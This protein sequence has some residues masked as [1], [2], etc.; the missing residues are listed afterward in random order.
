MTSELLIGGSDDDT[1]FGGEGDDII[2]GLGGNDSLAGGDGDDVVDGGRGGDTLVGNAGSDVL[3]GNAGDDILRGGTGLDVL[4]GGTGNDVLNGGAGVDFLFGG[5][6]RDRLVAT[7]IATGEV[8][9]GGAGIDTLDLSG[10][11]QAALVVLNRVTETEEGL[12]TFVDGFVRDT[13]SLAGGEAAFDA[14]LRGLE[15]VVGTDFDDDIT[16]NDRSN[17]L[18]GGNGNDLLVGLGGN[19]RLGGGAGNDTL[20]GGEGTDLARFNGSVQRIVADLEDGVAEVGE[21]TNTLIDIENLNGSDFDDRI[22]GDDGDNRLNGGDGDDFIRGRQGNDIL[23]GGAGND[24][25]RGDRGE[26]RLVVN[27]IDTAE[28]FDGGEDTNAETGMADL[29]TGDTVDLSGFSE[30]VFVDLDQDFAGIA[31]P[32]LGQDGFI[33]NIESVGGGEITFEADLIDVEN[34]FGTA[35]DD[36]LFGNAEDNVLAGLDGDDVFHAFAGNDIYDGGDGTDLALFNQATTG[37]VADLVSGVVQVGT[38]HNMLVSIEDLNGGNFSDFIQGNE[39][40]NRLNGRG[41]DDTIT[42]GDGDDTLIGGD[43]NDLLFGG[44]GQDVLIAGDGA[45]LFAFIGDPFNGVEASGPT[46]TAI[47][48]VNRPDVA[49]DFDTDAD[50]FGFDGD[51][52]GVSTLSF[53]SATS[54]ALT[55]D[56][57]VIVL[58]DSFANAR[59][60]AGAIADNDHVT[61][62]RGFFIYHNET[63]GINRL[64]FS[65]D[66]AEGGAFSVLANLEDQEGDAGIDLLTT[67][68]A[69]NFALI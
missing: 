13:G 7:T 26:D 4:F 69:D 24:N 47:P 40:D 38:D 34:V 32:G 68:S 22:R 54:D 63:L 3:R 35:F 20:D 42:G 14:T 33:R 21:D 44:A 12:T 25:L 49:R 60:A 62:D 2:I 11:M 45:D 39:E 30:G 53:T 58:Q 29:A 66:L 15:R 59:A 41:G 19:D 36:R 48:G 8:F 57:N 5:L 10:L 56:A 17:D 67:Y 46:P 31:A 37:I 9:N 16:G 18:R 51:D 6:G 65:D 23:I 43:G 27:S 28:V 61:A 64:V 52:F 1:I 50:T 55:G